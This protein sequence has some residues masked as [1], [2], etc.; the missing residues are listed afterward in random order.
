MVRRQVFLTVPQLLIKE[1]LLWKINHEFNVVT[2]I[3]GASITEET[4][5]LALMLEGTDDVIDEVL[6]FLEGHGVKVEK[7]EDEAEE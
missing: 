3:R 4:A 6:T 2:N 7:L 1:P 5:L